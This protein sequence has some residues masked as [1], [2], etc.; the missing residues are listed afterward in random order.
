MKLIIVILGYLSW[1]YGKAI[2]SLTKIWKNFLYFIFEFFSIRLL[3]LNFF[4]PWKRMADKYPASFDLKDYF[5]AFITNLI[6]RAVGIIMRTGLLIIALACCLLFILFYP[7]ILVIWL[8]LPF[9][10]IALFFVGVSLII[11]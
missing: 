2:I 5:N 7:L 9:I 8:L 4:D 3:F 1:H 10:I 11:N 6:V